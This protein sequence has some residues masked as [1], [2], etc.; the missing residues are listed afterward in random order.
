MVLK[1]SHVLVSSDTVRTEEVSTVLTSG[2]GFL[3]GLTA[4]TD[5]LLLLNSTYIQCIDQ[6]II[7]LE[8]LNAFLTQLG[9]LRTYKFC[10]CKDGTN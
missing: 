3:L 4:C 9:Y 8:I 1:A 2:R 10:T 7:G 5:Y 6:H